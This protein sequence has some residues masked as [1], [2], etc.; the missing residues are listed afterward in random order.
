MN[1][2]L[3]TTLEDPFFFSIYLK[4]ILYNYPDFITAQKAMFSTL[5]KD[6]IMDNDLKKK[7]LSYLFIN[8]K[9]LQ[10]FYF[11]FFNYDQKLS[12]KCSNN[13]YMCFNKKTFYLTTFFDNANFFQSVDTEEFV[14]WVFFS[15]C[16]ILFFFFLL[17]GYCYSIHFIIT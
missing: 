3:L 13:N 12:L 11:K 17:F 1:T 14:Y 2:E 9:I 7:T 5:N 8:R 6:E 16:F 4:S 15:I 10:N